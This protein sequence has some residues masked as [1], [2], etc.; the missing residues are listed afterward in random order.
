M[1]AGQRGAL[2]VGGRF[3][4]ASDR[5]ACSVFLVPKCGHEQVLEQ[6]P[7]ASRAST[8]KSQHPSIGIVPSRW[9]PH[10]FLQHG[11]CDG[12]LQ[13]YREVEIPNLNL[14]GVWPICR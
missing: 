12:S 4:L 9:Q 11:W 13:A 2:E 10:L 3:L 6:R 8:M 7:F 5:R 14:L 1:R